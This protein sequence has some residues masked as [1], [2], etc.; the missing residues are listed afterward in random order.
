MAANKVVYIKYIRCVFSASLSR[1]TPASQSS[2]VTKPA[3]LKEQLI[4]ISRSATCLMLGI[5]WCTC[6]VHCGNHHYNFPDSYQHML[7]LQG[8]MLF[9]TWHHCMVY[10]PGWYPQSTRVIPAW[11]KNFINYIIKSIQPHC[12]ATPNIVIIQLYSLLVP[13]Y[14]CHA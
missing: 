9:R 1:F 11:V 8:L 4:G 14:K 2:L 13:N 7:G 12:S 3:S 10:S 6:L 5:V